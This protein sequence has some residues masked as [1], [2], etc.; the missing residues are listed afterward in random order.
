MKV[1]LKWLQGY[2]DEP[3]P[4]PEAVADAFT[5]HSFEV[6]GREGDLFDLKVLPDRAGYGLCH[7]GVAYELAAALD[8]PLKKDPLRQLL[9][10]PRPGLGDGALKVEIEDPN[11]CL[12]Y[13]GALV[14]GVTVGPSPAWLKEALESVG[15]RSINNIVDAT[16]YV[17]LNI[18]QPLH[19]FDAGKLVQK[20]GPYAIA[21]R[22]AKEREKITTL[23]GDEYELTPERVLIVDNNCNQPIGIA[24]VKGGKSAQVDEKTTDLIVESANFDG[25]SVRRT[26]QALKLFTDASLRFQN[27]PSPELCAY[28][29]RD[30]LA[31]I[32]EIAGGEVVSVV[33]EYPKKAS[34]APVIT[35]LER[36]NGR[37]G[38]AFC[39]KDVEEVLGR[40]DL[41]CKVEG[42]VVTVTPPFERTD[43]VM[44]E[45]IAEEVG[46]IMGYDRIPGVQ[47]PRL[48]GEP[49]QARY[50]G[51]EKMKD[52]LLEAGFTE[53]STQS[54]TRTGEVYLANPLDKTKPALRTSLEENLQEALERAERAAPLV[55]RPGAKPKLFEVGT[56][57]PKEGEYLELRMTEPA[58]EGL[59]AHDNLTV[60]KLEEYGKGY[61]PVRYA[62]GQYQPFSN[63]PFVL[64]DIAL[65]SPAGTTP[66]AI[67]RLIRESAGELLKRLDL[68]D[69]FAKEGR[70]SYAFRLVFESM[71]R[72]LTDE[73]VNGCMEKI[74]TALTQKGYEIR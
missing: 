15:Q 67:E 62:L 66:E 49:D 4:A 27:R 60:A 10:S 31:L 56:V 14:K 30:V 5:F 2:F 35:T 51:I 28:G 36:I 74:S 3:L 58:W 64:R 52:H 43:I 23:T 32:T 26:A 19:A 54:F 48:A 8:L 18:G 33:D 11:I 6:D 61:E 21:V 13:M 37:L 16:N 63:Y 47:L 70:V 25:T 69:R 44:P 72:T 38:S 7:R 45:D 59:P 9:P 29:M 57:F 68:F 65:W 41:P 12:R 50:R 17:M 1:S 55:L 46:R 71:E 24:G 40:L 34:F 20:E 39:M 53:V 42:D 73:E 22:S